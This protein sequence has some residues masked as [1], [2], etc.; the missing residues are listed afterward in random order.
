MTE[1]L[2]IEDGLDAIVWR[3][4]EGDNWTGIEGSGVGHRKSL[5]NP[6]AREQ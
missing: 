2:E 5:E 3:L 1:S 6:Q 4:S